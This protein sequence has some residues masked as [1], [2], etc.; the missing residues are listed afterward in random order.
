[1]C[2][3]YHGVCNR[4]QSTSSSLIWKPL[5]TST[6]CLYNLVATPYNFLF[7]SSTWTKPIPNRWSIIPLRNRIFE[8]P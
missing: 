6:W 4:K 2:R 8:E 7:Q 1:L 5:P 3:R